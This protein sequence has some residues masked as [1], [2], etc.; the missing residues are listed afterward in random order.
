[1]RPGSASAWWVLG[2]G[3]VITVVYAVAL[4][5]AFETQSYNV[6]GSLLVTPVLGAV[7][8]G[9]IWL[10][11]RSGEDP[12]VV[13]LLGVAFF[14]KMAA[15]FA[16]YLMVF[17]LYGGGGDANRYNRYAVEQHVLWRQGYFV[18]E[19]GGKS[20]TQNLELITTA[21]YTLIGPA[22]LAAFLVFA[23]LSFWG[24][25]FLY[26]AFRVAVPGGEHR[27]YAVLVLLM[28]SLLF[29]PSSIGKE[30]W[31]LLW[32]GVG[33]LGVA[34]VFNAQGGWLLLALAAVGTV[35][36]RP[37]FTLLLAVGVLVAQIFRPTG[38]DGSGTLRKAVGLAAV[39]GAVVIFTTQSAEFLGI[40]DLDA[41]AVME[42]IEWASGQTEQGGSIFEPVPLSHPL[43]IPAAIMTM[44]FRP[45][46]WE[47][48]GIAMLIQ[49]VEGLALIG[50]C[51]WR[52]ASIRQVPRLVRSNPYVAFAVAYALAFMLAFAGFSNFGIL[53][54]Q[55]TLM[56]PL[57][58]VILALPVGK[59]RTVGDRGKV[60]HVRIDEP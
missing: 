13:R 4:A 1:M 45:F 54:R 55:R 9:L 16:R 39:V 24:C 11:G 14:A 31:L 48:S 40:E 46:P 15:S 53:A 25:Y 60:E 38:A 47:A 27:L 18:W 8:L 30:A 51:W 17:V 33:A 50:L 12:W 57:A 20:G 37:H 43:G 44:L 52:R 42:T 7:N 35:M 3:S 5:W 58:L 32:I 19:P 34:K 26:R 36:I 2:I 21:V 59:R 28:P 49:S 10:V 56:L 23:T 6:W 29:W 22:P 41:T